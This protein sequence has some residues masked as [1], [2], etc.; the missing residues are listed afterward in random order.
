MHESAAI[1][2]DR[3]AVEISVKKTKANAQKVQKFAEFLFPLTVRKQADEQEDEQII[4]SVISNMTALCTQAT[5]IQFNADMPMQKAV[6]DGDNQALISDAIELYAPAKPEVDAL[7]PQ[8]L[9]DM[10]S[11][12]TAFDNKSGLHIQNHIQYNAASSAQSENYAHENNL[13][14]VKKH[15]SSSSLNTDFS[16]ADVVHSIESSKKYQKI[17]ITQKTESGQTQSTKVSTVTARDQGNPQDKAQT[18]I[19][20]VKAQ[21]PKQ[22]DILTH[23]N[24]SM[25][26]GS[27]TA[28]TGN[29]PFE[30]I[31]QFEKKNEHKTEF[32]DNQHN[33][34]H[35]NPVFETA[36]AEVYSG[37]ENSVTAAIK[38]KPV[39]MQIT[40]SIVNKEFNEKT[41]FTMELWPE[42]LGRVTVEMEYT[43]GKLSLRLI[44]ENAGTSKLLSENIAQLKYELTDRLMDTTNIDVQT[45]SSNTFAD[46]TEGFGQQGND[47]TA[48]A[49]YTGS[50]VKG[51]DID[52]GIENAQQII[53][54]KQLL[55]YL[56]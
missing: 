46:F 39:V 21:D 43:D 54:A 27:Q 50:Y 51:G 56:V 37:K 19:Q 42:E 38:N 6:T 11:Q 35:E 48:K 4:T 49:R 31:I 55:N 28:E 1:T 17:H 13:Q 41:K 33:F 30:T 47:N 53:K 9:Q 40:D 22:A 16:S 36:R 25:V 15:L 3:P 52:H 20:V 32:G 10:V 5:D 7:L 26:S 24:T 14:I 23:T 44:A 18:Q 34:I 45:G 29:S 8:E 2:A 12:D